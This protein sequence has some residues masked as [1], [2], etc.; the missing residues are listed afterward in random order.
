MA[1]DIG[2]RLG[3]DGEKAFRSSINAIN[4]N[5]KAMGSELKAVTAQFAKN[6]DS[7][8]ALTA[9]NQVLAKSIAATKEKISVLDK[10]LER[11]AEKLRDLGQALDDVVKSHGAESKEALAAQ[12]AY[13]NQAKAV[14]KLQD[15]LN[16][17]KA[18]LAGMENAVKDNKD[19]IDGLGREVEDAGDAFEEAGQNAVSFGDIL[20]ANIISDLVVEGIRK[21]T[22]GLKDFARFSLES[23]M[24]FEAQMSRVQAISGATAEEAGLLADKAKEMGESTVFS[25][26]ESAQALEY[27]AM[28]G[29]K[30][31]DMLSGLA[32]IM[33]L[34]AASGEDLAATSDIVTDA[35]TAFGLT[36]ADS[37]HF[38]D[39]LAV[40]S[41]NAN[42]NVGMM[43]ET[44]KYVA[45]V[46]GAMGYTVEDAA[47]AIGLM[48][49]SSIKASSAGT[50]LRTLMT[51]MAKPTSDMADAMYYLG[52]SLTDDEGNMH[53]FMEVMDQLRDGFKGGR[54]SQEEYAA[55]MENWKGMYERGSVDLVQYTRAVTALDIALNGTNESQQAEIA[56][57]LAGKEAMSGLLAIVNASPAD[58]QKLIDAIYD[59]DGAAEAMSKTM[60]DN[61]SGSLTL[62]QSAAEGVGISLYEKVKEPLTAVINDITNNALPAVQQFID[63]VDTEDITAGI[64]GF[65]GAMQ[66]LIPVLVGATAAMAAYKTAS[67]IAGL[68]DKLKI[69]T[70]SQ[71]VAQ[72]ALNA[73]MNANPFVLVATLIAGLVTALVTLY[74]TNETFRNK[75]NAAW[76]SVTTTISSGVSKIK[77]FFTVDIPNAGQKALN[78]F[79]DIPDQLKQVG[80]DL[81]TSLWNGINDK[82]EWLKKKVGGV[83]DSIKGVFGGGS[84]SMASSGGGAGRRSAVAP[85]M[86]AAEA[87]EEVG[88]MLFRA[89]RMS[90]GESFPQAVTR[91]LSDT[92][93]NLRA[94][95][96]IRRVQRDMADAGASVAAYY[97]APERRGG[98]NPSAGN[99]GNGVDAAAIGQAVREALEGAKVVVDGRT[100]GRVTMTQQSNMGRAFGTA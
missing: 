22:D 16:G 37:T 9:K 82:V 52:V 30:T 56:A 66:T 25:A 3:V 77:T 53:S 93:S 74:M 5:I 70:N 36:A 27:M 33:N 40:A 85:V 14:A 6:A 31:D 12:N 60:T 11:Q 24:N 88:P 92:E 39:V 54:I 61:L 17:A 28:A 84:S 44:F 50:A 21:I 98:G 20:K 46:A 2:V 90:G 4:A 72:A 1:Y 38:A 73:V 57:M 49:N 86:L 63:S 51:N 15:Q 48:A 94:T 69:A 13:N 68:I 35:L 58:Y 41:S 42:T 55:A 99:A 83:I 87:G 23:G 71:T 8:E 95:A 47:V 100:L 97:T 26:T 34:A 10:Q 91:S 75:V 79:L 32:G 96:A 65:L 76:T 67:S 89:A 45:P 19:A 43:G 81:I 78:W 64:N 62:M 59:A 29:W 80:K 7:E 18:E